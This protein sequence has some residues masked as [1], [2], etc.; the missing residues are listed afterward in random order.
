MSMG[1]ILGYP[2]IGLVLLA[3]IASAYLIFSD[4]STAYSDIRV[5][6]ALL[7]PPA[8]GQTTASAYFDVINDGGANELLFVATPISSQVEL[9]TH[10]HADG[11]M[12]MRMVNSVKILPKQTTQFKR[13]GLHVMIFNVEIP[14]GLNEVP[15]TLTFARPPVHAEA[16]KD[17]DGKK[18]N[19]PKI[20]TITI[21]AEIEA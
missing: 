1:K 10:L 3:A 9:H 4:K 16:Q 21:F 6:N 5:E 20:Y 8:P 12:K 7:R 11:M 18:I 15:L 13:M 19:M 14:E 2:A 17:T